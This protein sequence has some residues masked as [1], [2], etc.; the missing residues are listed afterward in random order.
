MK[1]KMTNPNV[2]ERIGKLPLALKLL[3]A[4]GFNDEQEFYVC[5]KPDIHLFNNIVTEIQSQI[6]KIK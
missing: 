4:I 3:K 6:D 1:I 2:Q 5:S